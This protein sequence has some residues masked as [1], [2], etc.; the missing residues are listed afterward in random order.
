VNS[1]V[2]D[3]FDPTTGYVTGSGQNVDGEPGGTFT[4]TGTLTATSISLTVDANNGTQALYTGSFQPDNTLSGSWNQSD[5]SSGTWTAVISSDSCYNLDPETQVSTPTFGD[6]LNEGSYESIPYDNPGIPYTSVSIPMNFT[7]AFP[8][9]GANALSLS[10]YQVTV[11]WGNLTSSS[12]PLSSVPGGGCQLT[13]Q[14]DYTYVGVYEVSAQISD[15]SGV[16]ATLGFELQATPSPAASIPYVGV[17][18]SDGGPQCTAT[19]IGPYS[20][21]S[22]VATGD[23]I[24]TAAH[25]VE[26]LSDDVDFD[27]FAFAPAYS[28]PLPSNTSDYDG[29]LNPCGPAQGP[30]MDCPLSGASAPYGVWQTNLLSVGVPSDPQQATPT[31]FAFLVMDEPPPM[32]QSLPGSNLSSLVGSASWISPELKTTVT[33]CSELGGSKNLNG[34]CPFNWEMYSYDTDFYFT[35]DAIDFSN[36]TFCPSGAKGAP[37]DN[38]YKADYPESATTTAHECTGTELLPG[39]V[40]QAPECNLGDESSGSPIFATNDENELLGIKS[41]ENVPPPGTNC[42]YPWSWADSSACEFNEEFAGYGNTPAGQ[43]MKQEYKTVVDYA[44]L[45]TP[46]K[47]TSKSSTVVQAGSPMLFTVS[48]SGNQPPC[49]STSSAL[50]SGV[51]FTP[52]EITLFGECS[53]VPL[54]GPIGTGV[55]GGTPGPQSGGVYPITFFADNEEAGSPIQQ[56]FT[57]T[58]Y[59]IPAITSATGITVSADASMTPFSVTTT[60]YPTPKVTASGLPKGLTMTDGTIAGIPSAKTVG[61]HNVTIT[62]SSKAGQTTQEFVLTVSP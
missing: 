55:L 58:V 11:N 43:T 17:L 34:N 7:D 28:G 60:G 4:F 56:N 62:A 38:C 5:G 6:T 22:P 46:I 32:Y 21:G 51:T 49:I 20:A 31:D 61:T 12:F 40:L 33:N 59:Q 27:D 41:Q 37:P 29:D 1:A 30:P 9:D 23:V 26:S 2:F 52:S 14:P 53:F 44:R 18:T 54:N 42:P 8:N 35:S 10:D 36:T 15:Q 24:V 48:A 47:F 50:P 39:Y 13:A 16:V 45:L 57:L 19:V 25:C 3:S